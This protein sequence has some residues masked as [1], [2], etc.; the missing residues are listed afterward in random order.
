MSDPKEPPPELYLPDPPKKR[1]PLDT[2]LKVVA[3]LILV[4]FVLAVL[5]FGTCLLALSR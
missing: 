4:A 5:V 3:I 1:S 2:A